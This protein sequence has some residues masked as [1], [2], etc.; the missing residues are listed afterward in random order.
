MVIYSHKY[1][2][3]HNIKLK[4][5]YPNAQYQVFKMTEQIRK[6]DN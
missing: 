1:F 5:Q 3:I 6:L 4:L 2:L